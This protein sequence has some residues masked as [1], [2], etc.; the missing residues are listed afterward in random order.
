M[1]EKKIEDFY[2]VLKEFEGGTHITQRSIA[3]KLGFSLGKVNYVLKAL[4]EKG[5]V[6]MER[7]RRSDNKLYYRYILTPAGVREKL[8]ITKE[9]IK[10]K[11][12]EF[13]RIRREIE[14]A[15]RMMEKG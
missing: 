2:Y 11:S 8:R 13:E 3:R 10:R 1:D 7:F 6:K 15:K 4:V 14:E 12:E 5:I 9:F